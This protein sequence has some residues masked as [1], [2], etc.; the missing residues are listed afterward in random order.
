[1]SINVIMD[2]LKALAQSLQLS[3]MFPAVLFLMTNVYILLPLS[4]LRLDPNSQPTTFAAIILSLMLSYTLYTFNF[5]LI[6]F[7][8]GYKLKGNPIREWLAWNQQQWHAYLVQQISRLERQR[9]KL[10]NDL[11]R[12][13]MKESSGDWQWVNLE[14]SRLKRDLDR[15][16]PSSAAAVLPT[17][18]GNTIAAFE[19]Y[20][21]TR[22]GMETIALW[23]RL[24]PLL[25]DKNYLSFVSQ[26]KTAF[27]F[28]MNTLIVIATLSGEWIVLALFSG[29][30]ALA[31][32]SLAVAVV[33]LSILY[34]GMVVAA[35]QWGTAVRVAFDLHRYDL[36]ERLELKSTAN[37]SFQDEVERWRD[38][39]RFFALRPEK[40]DFAWFRSQE[41]VER[42][43]QE[44]SHD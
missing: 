4:P 16:Y 26:E 17:T 7:F 34:H 41:E 14:L 40:P 33:V 15:N 25:R 37:E 38:I 42:I 10:N 32:I 12:P 18:L 28:L 6:R 9:T 36:H 35:R 13:E 31:L 11:Y 29:E 39:S 24:M 8:E 43:R 21:R 3:M 19:D 2:A 27:D 1:M 22:Y 20:P 30:I 5:P 23:P 44:K